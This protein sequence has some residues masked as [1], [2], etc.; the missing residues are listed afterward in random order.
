MENIK[1]HPIYENYGYNLETNG[2]M[3]VKKDC[4]ITQYEHHSGYKQIGVYKNK[5]T[6]TY[7][8]HRFI[9]ECV[10][11]IIPDKYEIDH[12]NKI[13]GDNNISNLRCITTN[14]NRQYR[15]HTNIKKYGALAHTLIRCIKAINRNTM[16]YLCFKSKNQCGKYFNISP[17]LIYLIIEKKNNVKSAN[18]S[19]GK[20]YFEYI[21]EKDISNLM[22]PPDKM[23]KTSETR[24]NADK[25]R[26]WNKKNTKL[27]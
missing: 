6:K 15:D 21:D 23:Y 19:L 24:R 20:Y 10:N 12:I 25:K 16:E 13:K 7:M 14:E 22:K 17:A 11:G 8:A 2:I 3:N 1:V 5:K 18:T 27:V 4:T 9:W 26:Y